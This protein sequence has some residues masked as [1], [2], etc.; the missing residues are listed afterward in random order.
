MR[1]APIIPT[2]PDGEFQMMEGHRWV[3]IG[4]YGNAWQIG[5]VR[6][7]V[8]TDSGWDHVSV[9]CENRCPS[10]REMDF[11]KRAFFLPQE[12]VIQLH[13]PEHEHV[14]FMPHCLHLWRPQYGQILRP[15]NRLVGAP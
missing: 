8:T 14:N 1:F 9:S 10:W 13:V 11:V 4:G 5:P 7:I 3:N 12:T 6:V 2:H 15:P